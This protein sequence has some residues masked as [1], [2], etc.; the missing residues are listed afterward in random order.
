MWSSLNKVLSVLSGLGTIV[1]CLFWPKAAEWELLPSS[2]GNQSDHTTTAMQT[3][4]GDEEESALWEQTLFLFK[5]SYSASALQ[6]S[7]SLK[8]MAFV[9][10]CFFLSTEIVAGSRGCQWRDTKRPG[11]EE[12]QFPGI[13]QRD[14]WQACK[15]GTGEPADPTW[16]PEQPQQPSSRCSRRERRD[17]RQRGGAGMRFLVLFISCIKN[18]Q[19]WTAPICFC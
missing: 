9:F 17:S 7:L 16:L 12:R 10:L 13:G 19:L 4:I 8:L 18:T 2:G 15:H 6:N 3:Y 11:L 5:W 14:H 1:L